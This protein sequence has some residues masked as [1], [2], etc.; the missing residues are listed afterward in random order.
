VKKFRHN[1]VAPAFPEAMADFNIIKNFVQVEKQVKDDMVDV[2][3][4]PEIYEI[5]LSAQLYPNKF[6]SRRCN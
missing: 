1:K 6:H 4:F 2:T 3:C 5:C